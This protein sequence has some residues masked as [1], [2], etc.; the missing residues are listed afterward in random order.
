PAWRVLPACGSWAITPGGCRQWTGAP[1]R[2]A[3][4]G[5]GRWLPASGTAVVRRPPP[6]R[7][8]CPG[9]D[10]PTRQAVAGHLQLYPGT[11]ARALRQQLAR[12]TRLAAR[13]TAP[14]NKQRYPG[15]PVRTSWPG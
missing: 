6:G 3:A 14:A 10:R 1:S 2:P 11:L 4:G 9:A 5:A 8:V 13:A 15:L 7:P 12:R